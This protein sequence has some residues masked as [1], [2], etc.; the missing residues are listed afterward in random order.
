MKIPI[1]RFALSI[2]AIALGMVTAMPVSAS[3]AP[4]APGNP[5]GTVRHEFFRSVSPGLPDGVVAPASVNADPCQTFTFG[6]NT[7]G[8]A[9]NWLSRFTQH[10]GWCWNWIQ[11][12]FHSYSYEQATSIG[13][14]Y[15]GRTS[16]T[17]QE[18]SDKTFW[19]DGATAR[20]R[21]C[22]PGIGCYGDWYPWV[23]TVVRA[24]GTA[25]GSG[26]PQ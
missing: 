7:Y 17:H 16:E 18:A 25:D 15:E 6:V 11:V 4:A 1:T 14:Q 13:V 26:S 9:G 8:Q 22:P 3:A 20:F 23:N 10:V 2:A 21:F 24:N 12:T 19:Q 5:V